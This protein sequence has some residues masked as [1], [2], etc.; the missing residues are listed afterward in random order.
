GGGSLETVQLLLECGFSANGEDH[1]GQTAL[2]IAAG[3]GRY[4]VVE[5][6]LDRGS[7]IEE[8]DD[9]DQT[10]LHI[11]AGKG[12]YSVVNILFDS[13]SDIEAQDNSG[14]TVLHKAVAKEGASLYFIRTFL[15]WGSNIKTRNGDGQTAL[16]IAASK[17]NSKITKYLLTHGSKFELKDRNGQTAW[18]M[19]AQSG[20]VN[21][22]GV[23]LN[24]SRD[25]NSRN[26]EGQT[27]LH[28]G[29]ESGVVDLVR[30]LLI[31]GC[32]PDIADN[33]GITAIHVA[34][35]GGNLEMVNMILKFTRDCNSADKH[36]RTV[37]HIAAEQGLTTIVEFL[38]K[39]RAVASSLNKVD[40]EGQTPL[41]KAVT[42]KHFEIVQLLLR[43]KH[44]IQLEPL[45]EASARAVRKRDKE[46][47]EFSN[48]HRKR[49]HG[50]SAEHSEPAE[51]FEFHQEE[52]SDF[53]DVTSNNKPRGT[54]T[55]KQELS[56]HSAQLGL[57]N[58]ALV[59]AVREGDKE[60][61]ELLN[62]LN[63][64]IRS[65][66]EH[67][68]LILDDGDSAEFFESVECPESTESFKSDQEQNPDFEDLDT[69][70]DLNM[71][72]HS[73]PEDHQKVADISEPILT[74]MPSPRFAPVLDN[75]ESAERT[76]STESLELNQEEIPDF[77]D[78]TS[79]DEP[80]G[81]RTD[82][83][84]LS[85]KSAL[86]SVD[87]DRVNQ[88]TA[89]HSYPEDHRKVANISEPILTTAPLK[90]IL[91]GGESAEDSESD[92]EE[93]SNSE[94]ITSNDEPHGTRTDRQGLLTN[95]ALY[96]ADYDP[97]NHSTALEHQNI[98]PI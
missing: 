9:N 42:R 95:S 25:I 93:V 78:I 61:E 66:V 73:Y 44:R 5:V 39:K 64:R 77:Q 50:E 30:I 75:G 88:S 43:A 71:R 7:D 63:E 40:N 34:T 62:N 18:H 91:D 74:P 76:E 24:D 16:H 68:E 21:M 72:Q 84:E 79:N 45:H 80:R 47:E 8:K 49:I 55:E 3:K 81:A 33:N 53:K 31:I 54:R 17:G 15:E 11:A 83:Q 2:H 36:G 27:P 13:K 87:Y 28:I 35:L 38:L 96:S 89:Q 65:R 41:H 6:L 69:V 37:W 98:N 97:V 20:S 94:D 46:I 56:M 23:L 85:T 14:Q 52:I 1:N 19:A 48:N 92:Q 4:S 59:R 10:A 70:E 67:F 82:N 90:P 12:N 32:E 57:L 22:V 58:E 86:Y 60:T 29:I 51:S 26:N